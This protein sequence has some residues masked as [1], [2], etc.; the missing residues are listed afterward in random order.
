[1][2]SL[3][4]ILIWIGIIAIIITTGCISGST[5]QNN[6][7]TNPPTT[8]VIKKPQELGKFTLAEVSKHNQPDDCWMAL[9]GKVYDVTEFIALG[10]HG[11]AINQGYP[12]P[13][14]DPTVCGTF[15]HRYRP[16]SCSS[17]AIRRFLPGRQL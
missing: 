16:S 13:Y 15:Q 12:R 1:M 2:N 4:A 8:Q 5:T 6:G 17:R 11:A 7:E 3:S 14:P 10:K 9:N